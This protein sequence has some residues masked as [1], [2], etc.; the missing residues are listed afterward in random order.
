MNLETEPDKVQRQ[1][2]DNS[3]RYLLLDKTALKD[4]SMVLT[5]KNAQLEK[6]YREKVITTLRSLPEV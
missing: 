4:N 6:D 2:I 3:V 1:L 5:R